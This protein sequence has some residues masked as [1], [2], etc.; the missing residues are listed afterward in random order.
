MPI[1]EYRNFETPPVWHT[2]EHEGAV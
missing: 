2:L 1:P